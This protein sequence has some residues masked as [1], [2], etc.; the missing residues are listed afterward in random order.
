MQTQCNQSRS[1]C[2]CKTET[3]CEKEKGSIAVDQENI[4]RPWLAWEGVREEILEIHR[5]AFVADKTL[6]KRTRDSCQKSCQA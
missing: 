4:C 2:L 1:Q 5:G 6:T 3:I